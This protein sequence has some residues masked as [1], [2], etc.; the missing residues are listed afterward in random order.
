MS[1]FKLVEKLSAVAPN[2]QTKVKVLSDVA[3]EHNIEWDP[4][5]FEE[6]E[7]KPPNDLLVRWAF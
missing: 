5:S 4:T 6:K 2:V 3:K 1:C 7:S